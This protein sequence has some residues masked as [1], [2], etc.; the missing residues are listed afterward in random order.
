MYLIFFG[1]PNLLY[2]PT[3]FLSYFHAFL[4][5]VWFY[6]VTSWGLTWATCMDVGS[7]YP[8]EHG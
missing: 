4:S 5:S 3:K 8:L 2:P 6:F 1:H 7:S